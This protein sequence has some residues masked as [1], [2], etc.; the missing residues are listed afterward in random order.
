M[1]DLFGPDRCL[2]SGLTRGAY[3]RDGGVMTSSSTR[4]VRAAAVAT[5][6][7]ILLTGCGGAGSAAKSGAGATSATSV[8]Q[9]ASPGA[10]ASSPTPALA[11]P[12]AA[13]A[14]ATVQ[15]V[16]A[17]NISVPWGIAFLP[18]GNALVSGRDT[19]RIL[20]V[21]AAGGKK[22][23]GTVPG[24]VSNGSSGGEAGLLGLAV[25]PGF[26]S[27]HWLYAY[28]STRSDNR[29][30]RMK[31]RSG[32]LGKTHVI[33]KGIPTGLHH[34][35]GRIAFGPDHLLYVTTGE[36]GNGALAQRKSSLGGKIL[37]MTATGHVPSGNPFNS[38]VY[39][40]G[41]RNIEGLAWDSAGRLW[42]TE[43][44]DHAWDELNLILPGHNYGWP[45]TEGRTSHAGYTSPKAQWHTDNAGPSGIAIINNVA[46]IGGVTGHRLWRVQLSG[47]SV[48]SKHAFLIGKYGRLRT[49][50]AAPDGSLWLTTSN[51]DHRATPGR[52]DDRIFRLKVS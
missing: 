49:A 24:V 3:V 44:G 8:S 45:A 50:A 30:V 6:V 11:A 31:Y 27:N 25:S 26:S 29:V 47:T 10:T 42:A 1:S 7:G 9:Q 34:N 14:S 12:K 18:N 16:L 22:R 36:S 21:S 15:R 48:A 43:F 17:R 38:L 40:Y 19:G 37:R 52:H 46:W 2:R 32:S 4:L 35:G 28:L 13:A 39:S 5:T 20:R 41:H 33:L 51:T 23:I